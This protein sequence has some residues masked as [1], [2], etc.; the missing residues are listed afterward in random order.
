MANGSTSSVPMNPVVSGTLHDCSDVIGPPAFADG[1]GGERQPT[2][3][4]Q[5]LTRFHSAGQQQI[6]QQDAQREQRQQQDRQ[7]EQ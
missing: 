1:R 4:S 3:R 7:R 2:K 5:A 6:D